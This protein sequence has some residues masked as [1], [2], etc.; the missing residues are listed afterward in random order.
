MYPARRH[1]GGSATRSD[2]ARRTTGHEHVWSKAPTRIDEVEMG[3]S[4]RQQRH[5]RSVGWPGLAATTAARDGARFICLH[6]TK[7]RKVLTATA[8]DES[9]DKATAAPR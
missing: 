1:D 3:R 2:G 7:I 9:G 8:N 4:T 5:A 6:A